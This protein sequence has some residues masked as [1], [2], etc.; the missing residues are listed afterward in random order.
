[1][2]A[3]FVLVLV[4]SLVATCY[5]SSGSLQTILD[6]L[7]SDLGAPEGLAARLAELASTKL[8]WSD[9]RDARSAYEQRTS[10]SSAWSSFLELCLDAG[11]PQVALSTFVAL[12]VP[13]AR[14]EPVCGPRVTLRTIEILEFVPLHR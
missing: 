7:L 5:A 10:P 9:A 8:G 4:L 6:T 12:L 1:M 3:A 13:N 11:I 2:R 14:Y